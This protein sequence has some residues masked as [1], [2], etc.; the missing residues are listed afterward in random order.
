MGWDAFVL[1]LVI[2][3]C[4]LIP[5][6][7]VFHG[8]VLG[9]GSWFIYLIDIAFLAD[10]ILNFCTSFRHDG[11]EVNDPR[12]IAA[13]YARTFLPV[14]IIGVLPL[15]IIFLFLPDVTIGGC[16]AV[17]VFRL[18]RLTRVARLFLI[19]RRWVRTGWTNPGYLR[20]AKF[21][22]LAV[23]LIHWLSCLWFFVAAVDDFPDN[24]WVVHAGI[25]DSEP[26]TQYI[27]SLYW[28]ITTMTTVGYGDITPARNPEFI[29]A[30]II[31]LLGASMYAFIIG[32]VA[33][34][35]S[36]LDS[37]KASYWN[38][39]ESALEYLRVRQVPGGLGT[40]VRNYY[41]YLWSRHKGLREDMLFVELPAPLRLEVL[42][43]LTKDLMDTVPLFKYCSHSLRNVLLMAL[44]SQ[45]CDPGS[46]VVRADE[47]G[48][49]MFFIS[50]GS[51]DVIKADGTHSAL[52]EDGDYFGHVSMLFKEK[53]TASVVANTYC[54]IFVLTADAFESIRSDYPEL[55]DVMKK[56]SSEGSEKLAKLTLEGVVL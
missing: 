24:S 18:L 27:R 29:A 17:L 31:M 36:S 9:W 22:C 42:L 55:R 13:H 33:S 23:V 7:L 11:T 32:N 15:D 20:I 34:L 48:K 3:S 41:E 21:V 2:L 35:L 39:M 14:D 4:V 51:L 50:R 10:I 37:V 56:M 12:K 52:L 54:E 5:Y 19:F 28:T 8:K 26:A 53:R 49:E 47:V 43:H 46:S 40:R 25:Q 6:H 16:S 44:K 30:M 1:L 38:K 45:T